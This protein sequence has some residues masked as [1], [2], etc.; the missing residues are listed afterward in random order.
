MR[1]RIPILLAVIVVALTPV[2]L[3][4]TTDS[5]RDARLPAQAQQSLTKKFPDWRPKSLSDL[6]ADDLQLWLKA[7]PKE[8]PGVAAGHFEDPHRLGYAVLLVPKS[9][10]TRGYRITVL[11]EDVSSGAYAAIVLDQSDVDSSESMVISTVPAGTY[12]DFERTKS[13]RLKLD[14]VN[15]EWIE[16]ASLLYYWSRG[17]YRTIQTSD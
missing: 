8:C 11:R 10:S 4:Q 1:R 6:G 7:S 16:K 5:C 15:V 9:G 13:V 3:P 12:S 14:S 2:S 17:K